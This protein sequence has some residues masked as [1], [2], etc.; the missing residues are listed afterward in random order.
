M[1]EN[2]MLFK[3]NY[4]KGS[5]NVFYVMTANSSILWDYSQQ[6]GHWRSHRIGDGFHKLPENVKGGV[7]CKKNITWFFKGNI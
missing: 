2:Y 4:L 1:R 3:Y 7:R 5:K 6:I